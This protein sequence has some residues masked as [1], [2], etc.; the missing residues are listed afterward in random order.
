M[1]PL[2][3]PLDTNAPIDHESRNRK[4]EARGQRGNPMDQQSHGTDPSLCCFKHD[5]E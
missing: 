5:A 3:T 2:L 4:D 1:S